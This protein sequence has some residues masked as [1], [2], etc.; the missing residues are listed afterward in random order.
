VIVN[1]VRQPSRRVRFIRGG[2]IAA[3]A[4]AGAGV[5]WLGAQVQLPDGPG[6]EALTKVC[7]TCHQPDRAAAVRLTREGW[8][9][10]IADMVTRGAKGTDEEFAAVLLYLTT[11]FLGEAARPLNINS[12]SQ[13]DLEMVAGLRRTE[14]AAVMKF[15]ETAG[16]CKALS[17]LKKVPGLE[18]KKIEDRKDFL[19][20]F[21]PLA[22]PK[23]DKS[24]P[25]DSR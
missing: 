14:A 23:K 12:A 18:Y 9:N 13:L 22:A 4:L 6:R 20:C 17:D 25:P 3:M 8:Q 16:L 5:T 2:V 1:T 7:G 21:P 24:L 11:N 19:V 10:V 15:L